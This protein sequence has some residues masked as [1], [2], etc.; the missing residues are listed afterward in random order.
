MKKTLCLLALLLGGFTSYQLTAATPA[1]LAPP[2]DGAAHDV[3]SSAEAR[4]HLGGQPGHWRA[5]LLQPN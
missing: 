3:Y 4:R 1:S 5:M 2:S